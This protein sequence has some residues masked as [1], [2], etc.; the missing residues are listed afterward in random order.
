LQRGAEQKVMDTA[1]VEGQDRRYHI[2]P[3]QDRQQ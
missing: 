3:F 2:D 1:K